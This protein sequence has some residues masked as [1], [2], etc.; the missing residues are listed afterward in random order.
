MSRAKRQH[1]QERELRHLRAVKAARRGDDDA[2]GQV[3]QG[4][5]VIGAGGQRLDQPQPRHRLDEGG[6]DLIGTDQQ[7]VAAVAN[8][9]R[10][11][12]FERGVEGQAGKAGAEF[13]RRRTSASL[14]TIN[15]CD[16]IATLYPVMAGLVP[17]IS[18]RALGRNR[19]DSPAITVLLVAGR[20][21]SAAIAATIAHPSA[22]EDRDETIDRLLPSPHGCAALP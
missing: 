11:S 22:G 9:R 10:A 3:G 14:A 8:L 6:G 20:L 21:Q 4:L 13:V 2:G 5:D 18:L 15:T 19:R 7:D 17:A 12:G 16:V 1:E